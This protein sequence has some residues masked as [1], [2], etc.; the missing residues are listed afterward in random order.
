MR[1]LSSISTAGAKQLISPAR[2]R[3]ENFETF[4]SAAGAAFTREIF[5]FSLQVPHSLLALNELREGRLRV[6]IS[7]SSLNLS[8]SPN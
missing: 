4:R 5:H 6:G 1:N 8:W 3:W 7:L 2:K